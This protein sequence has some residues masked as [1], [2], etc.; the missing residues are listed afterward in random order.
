MV[1]VSEKTDLDC[2]ALHQGY[3]CLLLAKKDESIYATFRERSRKLILD[4]LL[5]ERSLTVAARIA[6]L[7]ADGYT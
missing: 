2:A 4:L 6:R 3:A 1:F 7:N 5:R